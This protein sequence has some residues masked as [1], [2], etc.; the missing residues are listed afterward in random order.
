LQPVKDLALI[1]L[2]IKED[3]SKNHYDPVLAK[4]KKAS[5]STCNEFKL[6]MSEENSEDPSN[7]QEQASHGHFSNNYSFISEHSNDKAPEPKVKPVER[8][9]ANKIKM[10]HFSSNKSYSDYLHNRSQSTKN[11]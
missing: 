11:T 10:K 3:M 4:Y 1:S 6:V 5:L 8:K 7:D 2:K 9:I